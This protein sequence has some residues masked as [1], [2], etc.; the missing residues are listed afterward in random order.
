MKQYESELIDIKGRLR[1][2]NAKKERLIREDATLKS[3][4]DRYK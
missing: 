1:D 4:I 3:E 2:L